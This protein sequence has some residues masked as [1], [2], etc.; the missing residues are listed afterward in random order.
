MTYAEAHGF[1]E[2]GARVRVV[3]PISDTER[4]L[5]RHPERVYTITRYTQPH[6]YAV[7]HE[8]AGVLK[9][10]WHVHPEALAEIADK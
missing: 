1:P 4:D 8:I 6:G 2:V 7:I 10:Q 5:A 3:R 9:N